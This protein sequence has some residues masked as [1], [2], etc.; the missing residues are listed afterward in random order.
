[1]K[2]IRKLI[3]GLTAL[4]IV[5][6]G[7]NY[8]FFTLYMRRI[9]RRFKPPDRLTPPPHMSVETLSGVGWVST[10]KVS[11]WVNYEPEKSP[12]T[13]R[14]GCFGGSETYGA[15]V[16]DA[17]DFPTYLQATFLETSNFIYDGD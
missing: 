8:I 10:D 11:S 13:I 15:E 6:I 1:M 7:I 14:I 17:N 3:W 4:T 5:L 12:G 16:G 9:Q 2:V